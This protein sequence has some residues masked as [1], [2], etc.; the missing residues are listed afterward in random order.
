MLQQEVTNSASGGQ[1]GNKYEG[2]FELRGTAKPGKSPEEVE[3][4][5]YR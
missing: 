5:L 4:A 1:S 2:Y 3:Q